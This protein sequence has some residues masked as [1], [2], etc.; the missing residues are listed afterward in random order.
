[1]MLDVV[2]YVMLYFVSFLFAF[3]LWNYVEGK[4]VAKAADT[5]IQWSKLYNHNG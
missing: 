2:V 4:F 3:K 5:P 1:M